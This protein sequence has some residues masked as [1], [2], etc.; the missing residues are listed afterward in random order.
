MLRNGQVNTLRG[1][2]YFAFDV[3]IIRF[4]LN[5]FKIS[6]Y[7]IYFQNVFKKI[8]HKISAKSFVYVGTKDISFQI[9]K[10]C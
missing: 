5:I 9:C 7:L 3:L 2:I 6:I 4:I 1:T 8:I 10:S